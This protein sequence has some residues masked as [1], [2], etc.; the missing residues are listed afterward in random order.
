MMQSFHTPLRTKVVRFLTDMNGLSG[1]VAFALATVGMLLSFRRYRA[2]LYFTV[3]SFGAAFGFG[4]IKHLM[5][6]PRPSHML[7]EQG[8]FSFPSG[9]A[10]MAAAMALGFYFVVRYVRGRYLWSYASG[11]VA[12][13]CMFVI[14]LTRLYLGVHWCSDVVAGWALG[15]AW[16]TL[17]AA[18]LLRRY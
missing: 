18:L 17:W 12:L 2:T 10:T 15:T 11:A 7:I 13:G 9:H 5:Q 8:G 3:T 1:A 16:A 6:R 4:Y 14:G